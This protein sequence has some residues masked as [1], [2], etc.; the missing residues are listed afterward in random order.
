MIVSERG[1]INAGSP[2]GVEGQRGGGELNV[3]VHRYDGG[4]SRSGR[5]GR[6]GI[7]G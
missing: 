6:H 3:V 2:P 5:H 7:S 1:T 4:R